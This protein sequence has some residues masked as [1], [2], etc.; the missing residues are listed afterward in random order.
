VYF[1]AFPGTVLVAQ[2]FVRDILT[3]WDRLAVPR[4]AFKW[5]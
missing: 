2:D 4:L 5:E 3:R 1:G